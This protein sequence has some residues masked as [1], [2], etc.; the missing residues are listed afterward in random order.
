LSANPP[1]RQV[2][3]ITGSGTLVW[4]DKFNFIA[5]NTEISEWETDK[6]AC[7]QVQRVE[8]CEEEQGEGQGTNQGGSSKPSLREVLN[9]SS[10]SEEAKES[11]QPH[12][13]ALEYV[14]DM[15]KTIQPAE[16][17]C[18]CQTKLL[19]TEQDDHSGG[20]EKP[21]SR[22]VPTHLID[23][24]KIMPTNMLCLILPV[25]NTM[26]TPPEDT[27]YTHQTE[28]FLPACIAKIL[29][30]VQIGEDVTDAQCQEVKH[31]IAEYADCFALSLS[32]VNLVPSAVHKLN[33]PENST[34]CTKIP[35]CSFNPD[36]RAFMAV[37]VQ[38]M[39]KGGI[40]CPMHP[41][42]VH[43]VAPSVL[44]QKAHK[45]TGLSLDEL[46][47]KDNNE[48]VDHGL[49]MAFNMPPCPPPSSD[50]SALIPPKKWCLCQDFHKINKVMTIAPVPQGD[51]C[52]KQLCL[53][54]HR[55]LHIFNFTA[56][57]YG[58]T[59]HPDSQPYITF[60]LEGLGYFAYEQMP[61]GITG[62]LSEFRHMVAQHMHDLITDGTCENFINNGGS[63]ADSFKEGIAKL[64]QILECVCREKL[65]LSPSKLHVF[66]TEA[67]FTGAHIG[68]GG[69]S[70]DS[71][72]LMAVVNW[73]IPE[74]VSHLEGFLGLTAYFRDF[75]K[76]YAALEKPLCDLLHAVDIPN[77]TRK[78]AY[79]WI[80]KAY[81]LQ[82]HWKEEHTA[83]FIN[84]KAQLVSEPVLTAPRF[85]S[86]HFILTT[87][88]CKDTFT[89][90]LSQKISTTLPGGKEVTWLH[91]ISFASKQT[92][93]SEKYKPFLL[94]FAMLKY[95]FDKFSDII[96]GYPVKVETDCQV[97]CDILLSDK[98][99]FSLLHLFLPDSRSPVG[100]LLDSYWI[101][102]IFPK[103]HFHNFFISLPTG[104]L[105]DS[106]WTPTGLLLDS[107]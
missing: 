23:H 19:W 6:E 21:P 75:V 81:K 16:S 44:A 33:I 29:E 7:E 58:I 36:Q 94:E 101:S 85:D 100:F 38:E 91:S 70:P 2:L 74:D 72:K 67:V 69:V 90:V 20:N 45:N 68:P 15:P 26:E 89:G 41:G 32:E 80:M 22:G 47:H 52:T 92:S 42:E 78:A 84:L 46:K 105:L 97:L 4:N 103:R 8:W 34:F 66:M 93:L 5:D 1:L 88:A 104:L 59:I 86:T 98:Q 17:T 24:D 61:F 27:I 13:A 102:T 60:C 95:S 55:Y 82:L 35:Q 63:A 77:G 64:Q 3:H 73:K 51:I 53:S 96:Y 11:D 25:A 14:I 83:T 106:Y 12:G 49:P 107:Y 99:Y 65:T 76:G 79:Q 57:F 50:S 9:H 30:L 18:A 39:L 48:C 31:L 10:T 43:C 56:G 87:N 37:K 54:G 71:S 62:G 40:I 28:P